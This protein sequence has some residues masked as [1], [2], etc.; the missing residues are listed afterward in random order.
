MS[1]P[2][3]GVEYAA[4]AIPVIQPDEP[5]ATTDTT[6]LVS[7]SL[8]VSIPI[9]DAIY[10]CE[11]CRFSLLI[12]ANIKKFRCP[13]CYRVLLA[14][15][16]DRP[17]QLPHPSDRLDKARRS[18]RSCTIFFLCAIL[19]IILVPI[20]TKII[21]NSHKDDAASPVNENYLVNSST[22]TSFPH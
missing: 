14:P 13:H 3:D 16:L 4:V 7:P 11:S 10:P 9:A 17:I 20:L 18:G 1:A 22:G 8:G 2:A 15:D 19:V 12:P 6:A 5:A 21:Q